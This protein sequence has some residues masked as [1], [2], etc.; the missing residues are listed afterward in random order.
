MDFNFILEKKYLLLKMIFNQSKFEDLIKWK[1]EFKIS[2]TLK[3]IEELPVYEEIYFKSPHFEEFIEDNN[4]SEE[5]NKLME[6]ETYKKY[7]DET[8]DYLNNIEGNW[9]ENKNF[10][11]NW[12]EKTLKID[13]PKEKIPV[14]TSHPN[15][16]TGVCVDEKYIFWGHYRGIDDPHYNNIYLC[17]EMLQFLL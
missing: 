10:I 5:M 1:N 15:L 11:N 17:H 13:F 8:R 9:K 16:N 14:Y 7:Y 6:T 3:T 4:L 2:K 12:L